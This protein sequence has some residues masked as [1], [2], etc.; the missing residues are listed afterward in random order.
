M[1]RGLQDD[2]V[3]GL[4]LQAETLNVQKN[5]GDPPGSSGGDPPVALPQGSVDTWDEPNALAKIREYVGDDSFS[6]SVLNTAG[7]DAENKQE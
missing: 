1:L 7:R 6:Y 5:P 3:L 2:D 4:V